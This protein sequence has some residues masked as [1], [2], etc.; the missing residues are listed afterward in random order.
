MENHKA[1]VWVHPSSSTSYP[2]YIGKNYLDN[3]GKHLKDLIYEQKKPLGRCAIVTNP[4]TETHYANPIKKNLDSIGFKDTLL[5]TVPSGEENK[6]LTQ[7]NKVWETLLK[8]KLERTDTLIAVGGGIIGDLTGFAANGYLRGIRLIQVP[9]SLLAQ[10]D[11]SIGGKTGVNTSYGKN[12]IGTFYQPSFVLADIDCLTTLP[13]REMTCGLAEIIKYGVIMDPQLF[14]LLETHQEIL[15]NNTLLNQNEIWIS[16]ISKS[17]QNKAK[18][19]SADETEKGQ[20]EILNYGHTLG[21]AIESHYGYGTYKHGEAIAI[22][23][24]A[25]NA[26]AV[27]MKLL[28]P[29]SEKRINTLIKNLG[30]ETTLRETNPEKLAEKL[31]SD[32][33]VRNGECRFI[34]P[35]EIGNVKTGQIP[36][37][38]SIIETIEQLMQ[39]KGD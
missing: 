13:K 20:R 27:Q 19:V 10:V 1:A 32:K 23:M 36:S 38:T 16:L 6:T 5:I 8:N 7:V 28:K 39:K 22:G 24:I 2:V 37:Q 33:K 35:T 17:A 14:A 34:L 31:T 21:H 18:V 29:E 26:L 9:T 30:F 15:K 11:A 12:L 25:A 3:I 4:E